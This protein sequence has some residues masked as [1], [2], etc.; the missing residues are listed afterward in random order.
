MFAPPCL[1]LLP[2]AAFCWCRAFQT[3][4]SFYCTSR[5]QVRNFQKYLKRFS[6]RCINK[7]TTVGVQCTAALASISKALNKM[8]NE[9][10]IERRRST[11]S[12]SKVIEERILW[13][14]RKT[15][16]KI[17]WKSWQQT[18]VNWR[19][20]RKPFFFRKKKAFLFIDICVFHFSLI[21]SCIFASSYR[22]SKDEERIT[23]L[24][25]PI[26]FDHLQTSYI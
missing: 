14:K 1:P 26:S 22:I 10:R 13:H 20:K 7:K 5:S 15:P 25:V 2:G 8:Q 11:C 18:T 23:P 4:G 12:A 17:K 16:K 6:P 19:D 3:E 24:Q 21:L 9:L